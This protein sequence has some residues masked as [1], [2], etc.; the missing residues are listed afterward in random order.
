MNSA[1]ALRHPAGDITRDVLVDTLRE[2]F[3]FAD[4]RPGQE[5]IIRAILD[6]RDTLAVMPTGAGKSLIFQLPALLLDGL[7]VVVSPLIALMKDQTD[8]LEELGVDAL[9]INSGLT[10][11]EQREAEA[12]VAAG[13]GDILYVTPERFRDRE[14]FETL[15]ERRVALFVVD[16]A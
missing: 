10:A 15:L 13:A 11:R 4:F 14:F 9:T 12:A 2:R 3:G 5:A 6:G 7:T 16:E 1:T 8:K